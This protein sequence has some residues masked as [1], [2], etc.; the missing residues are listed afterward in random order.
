MAFFGFSDSDRPDDIQHDFTYKLDTV[1]YNPNEGLLGAIGNLEGIS[2]KQVGMGDEFSQ[3]YRNMLDPNSAYYQRLF[4]NL[5][6][7]VGSSYARANTNMQQAMAQRG[8]GKGGM[9][10][11]LSAVSGNQM[12]EQLRKGYSGIQDVGLQRAGQFGQ[13]ATGAYGSAGNI[14]SRVGDLRSGIDVRGLQTDMTNAATRNAY[15]QYLNTS[16]YN[17]RMAN[18]RRQDA[19]DNQQ[20]NQRGAFWRTAGTVVG[21]LLGG[22]AGA[23]G[24]SALM[25]GLTAPSGGSGAYAPSQSTGLAMSNF[26]SEYDLSGAGGYSQN[27]FGLNTPNLNLTY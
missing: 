20:A 27:N 7:D 17:L 19:Y 6:R 10:S 15:R 23:M 2:D 13:L 9:S 25:G 21:G 16:R 12:G 11:L 3:A 14:S 18:Q 1:D 24:A 5:R 8:I 4:G 26:P 22:P